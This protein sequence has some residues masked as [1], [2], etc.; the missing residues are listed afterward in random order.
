M[1]TLGKIFHLNFLGYVH[2][3]MS[4]G[5]SQLKENSTSV[6]KAKYA[7]YVDANYIHTYT[8]KENSKFHKT[9]LP[10]YIIFFKE[11]AST[12]DEQVEVMSR[13]YN[14]NYRDSV[15]SLIFILCTRVDLYFAL[16]NLEKLSSNPGEVNSEGML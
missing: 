1:Y 6:D 11:D 10:H 9:N 15:G 3:F 2:L 16:H 14:I 13:E 8:I 5:I 4:V 12:S 7:T